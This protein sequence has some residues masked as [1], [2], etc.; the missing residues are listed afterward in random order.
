MGIL[1]ELFCVTILGRQ[2]LIL[3]HT[4]SKEHN[5]EVDWRT[6]K[7]EMSR[8][9]PRCCNGCQTEAREERQTLKREAASI[10]ACCS[11]SFP[12]TVEDAEEEDA[13]DDEPG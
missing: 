9:S 4:W 12:A 6:G 13:S 11:S 10:S 5:L 1:K 2:N 8:C 3:G 7:V